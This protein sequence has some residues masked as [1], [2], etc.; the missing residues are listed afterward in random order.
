VISVTVKEVL[1]LGILVI[2]RHFLQENILEVIESLVCICYTEAHSTRCCGQGLRHALAEGTRN[3]ACFPI[4][5]PDHDPV[6][7][8]EGIQCMEFV[9][10]TND[11]SQGCNSGHKGAEQVT[12]K[13]VACKQ[14]YE[15]ETSRI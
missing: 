2:V 13:I 5:I 11:V 4:Q 12:A 9:R 7:S 8:R 15:S 10:T 14:K 1:R 6:Y 3:P